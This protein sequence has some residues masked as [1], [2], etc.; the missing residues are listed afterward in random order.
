MDNDALIFS[1]TGTESGIQ[2]AK[3]GYDVIMCPA[4]IC[5]FD[6]AHTSDIN[7]WGARWANPISIT[8]ILS[9]DPLEDALKLLFPRMAALA[10]VA[11]GTAY[12]YP[13]R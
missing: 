10:S 1:W 13:A 7:D 11:W 8:D 9:W 5:Y 6:M 2:A 12:Q 3:Q 4:Q